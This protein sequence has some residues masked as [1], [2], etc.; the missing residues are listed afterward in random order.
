M[1]NMPWLT[2]LMLVPLVGTVVVAVLPSRSSSLA[3]PLALGFSLLTL[4]IAIV[5]TAT[6][7][8]RGATEQFQMVEQHEWIPQIG[9]SYSLGVDG[10]AISLILM[11]LVLAP[12]CVLAAWDDV[13]EGGSREK[14]YFALMLLMVPFMV[15]VFAATDVFLFYIFFE[16]ML[17]PIYFLIGMY[18]G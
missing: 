13:P 8:T 2:L 3:K 6:S 12:V 10:I 11:A 17:I 14:T 5:A 4:L 15:G 9:V 7:Y 1:D 18:G 16:A